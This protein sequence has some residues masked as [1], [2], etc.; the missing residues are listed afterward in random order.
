MERKLTAIMAADV[1]GYSRMMGGD[2]AGTHAALKALRAEIVDPR[3][4]EHHGRIVKL[5]GDGALVEFASVVDALTCAVAIQR[6]MSERGQDTPAEKRIAF[7]IGINLGDIIVDGDDIYGNG[8]N[9][10]ARLEALAEPGGIC[11]SGRV[12]DQV[13][14]NVDVGFAS[15]GPQAVKNIEDPINAYKVLFDTADAG[16][17]VGA[18][19]AR[20]PGRPWLI[21][22]V[23]ALVVAIGGAGLWYHQTKPDF[24]PAAVAKMAYPLPDK[25]SIAVLPFENFSGDER[26]GFIARGL[27]ED[28][29]TALS[30]VPELFV[31]SRT[32][33]FA[34]KDKP[35]TVTE[36]AEE[37]G[38]RY[39]VEGSVQR[40]G[41]QIR[42]NVQ[43]IDAVDGHHLWADNFD[44][45]TEDLFALQDDIVR[46]IA[47]ELQVKLTFGEFT[48]VAA[49]GTTNL[50]AWLFN[51]QGNTQSFKFTR[52]GTARAREL[53][54]QAHEAD[55]NWARPLGGIAWCYFLEARQGWTDDREGW[56]RKGIEFAE[57]AIE[58]DPK[59]PLGYQQLG[60]IMQLQGDHD[61]AIAFREK[62]VELAPNDMATNWGLGVIL[63]KAGQAERGLEFLK[64]TERLAPRHPVPLLWSIQEA[65][66]LASQYEDSIETGKRAIAREAEPTFPHVLLVAAYGA[67]GRT[68]ESQAEAATIL[69]SDPS[70]TVT[71]FMRTRSYKNQS[72]LDRLSGSLIKAGLPE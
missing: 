17:I 29:I 62:A 32:S 27:T 13:K 49:R 70:F 66:F 50:D 21:A 60:N 8:V 64:R 58:M 22:A 52:E 65:Q 12:L 44:G 7:R 57:K 71:K 19:K 55:P 39:I 26:D 35:F 61:R 46:R 31:I 24:A 41:D 69:K 1:V 5:M 36:V 3:I 72:D 54:Q 33:S 47:I 53:Y 16:R 48:R 20:E 4:A 45:K 43:L 2:E 28:I 15:L 11:I 10:A 25:P 59:Q 68:E 56:I 30:S 63:Y 6:G 51:I 40:S 42:V 34:F 14:G 38:V 23:V 67:L 18:P 37:L 9:V